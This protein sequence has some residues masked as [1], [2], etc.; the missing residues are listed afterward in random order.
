MQVKT[1]IQL[2]IAL[3]FTLLLNAP[4]AFSWDGLGHMAVA[5]LAYKKLSPEKQR[6]V[7]ELLKLNPLYSKTLKTKYGPEIAWKERL[8]TDGKNKDGKVEDAYISMLAATWPD[9]IKNADGYD[10]KTFEDSKDSNDGYGKESDKKKPRHKKW[11]YINV[12]VTTDGSDTEPAES[13]N[14]QEMIGSMRK[15]IASDSAS[16]EVKSYNLTWLLHLVGDIHQPLHTVARFSRYIPEGDSG[17]LSEEIAPKFALHSFWDEL[18]GEGESPTYQEIYTAVADIKE[19]PLELTKIS[20]ESVWVNE[21]VEIAKSTVYTFK[22]KPKDE[23]I[24]LDQAYKDRA[25]AIAKERISLA[26]SRLAN[27]IENELK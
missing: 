19:A 8:E 5:Y 21:G 10:N 25:R 9:T 3:A 16:D 26:A 22:E 23:Y 4:A 12:P 2:S 6:R 13:P 27:L 11:H 24:E 14:A 20:D 1:K 7:N 17:G 15:I 18:L